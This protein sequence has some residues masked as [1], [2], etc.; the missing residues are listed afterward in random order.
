M[1]RLVLIKV[2]LL[3]LN[4]ILVSLTVYVVGWLSLR[5]ISRLM[6]LTPWWPAWR[7]ALKVTA[8]G[9]VLCATVDTAFAFRRVWYG[10][11][12][13]QEPVVV[14]T[15]PTPSSIVLVNLWC[16][17]RCLERLV[18]GVHREV[19]EVKTLQFD[20]NTNVQIGP[21][22]PAMRYTITRTAPNSC[23][24]DP[25]EQVERQWT[26]PVVLS[27]RAKGICPQIES[28]VAP[29][30]GVFII[31]EAKRISVRE[32]AVEFSLRF[33][34]VKLPGPI[35]YFSATEVQRRSKSGVELL[36]RV[37]AYEAPGF[38]GFPPLL[39]C[40]ERPDNIVA[41]IPFGEPGC[42][43]WRLTT[44][45]GDQSGRHYDAE[46]AYSRVFQAP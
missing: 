12:I 34:T 23:P 31:H 21:P 28:V 44:H 1:D 14:T 38:L 26:T 7:T 40:W 24:P 2:I 10:S 42:G 13:P 41:I 11:Q 8:I 19:I 9:L 37:E 4:P 6:N 5:E 27:L 25:G 18:S 43:L 33:L 36:G 20:N 29:T 3:A 16:K 35:S 30:D 32:P 39:G 45:G 46:W 22:Y 15:I 17:E